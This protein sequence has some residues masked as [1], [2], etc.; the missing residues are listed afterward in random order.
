M[1]AGRQN[2]TDFKL[3]SE[4]RRINSSGFIDFIDTHTHT[5]EVGLIFTLIDQWACNATQ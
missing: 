2:V 5:V 4:H 3:N 1:V